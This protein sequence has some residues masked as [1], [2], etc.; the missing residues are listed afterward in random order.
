MKRWLVSAAALSMILLAAGKHPAPSYS[1]G[2]MYC[3]NC[4][5]EYTQLAN[6]LSM[7]K[8]L[9]NQA[10]QIKNQVE[11]YQNM[12]QNTV[13]VKNQVWG[14]GAG[15]L[16]RLSHLL[17]QS[18]ALAY[19]A[20]NL[21]AQFAKRYQ[22]YQGYAASKN[23]DWRSK[24]NQWS[25]ESSD[26]ALYALKAA[27][28]QNAGLQDEHALMQRLQAMS[29]SSEGRMQ[30]AQIA[31]MMAAQQVEQ[32]Q[33]LRQLMMS[34]LAMQAN[35]YQ[36]QQDREDAAE[37]AHQQFVNVQRVPNNNGKRF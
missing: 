8:Q 14:N 36:L 29:Q 5:T 3:V 9:A 25:Q 23:L 30:A 7:A 17:Q 34:Q 1:A 11:Q 24:Y 4:G 2:A 10:V 13:G 21:D 19:S 32:I 33:K 35:Y 26:N 18:K 6:K 27:N 16:Q 28:L 22:G 20:G 15:Q 31:N 12:L 37:A